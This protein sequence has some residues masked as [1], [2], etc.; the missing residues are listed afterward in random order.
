M[1]RQ[2]S[3]RASRG[4]WLGLLA[5][6][7]AVWLVAR[8]APQAFGGLGRLI[9]SPASSI[10]QEN[11]LPGTSAWTIPNLQAASGI[12]GYADVVSAQ[13]SDRVR[14]F[15]STRAAAFHVEAYRIGYYGG[16]GARL[17]WRSR[18]VRG[19]VQAGPSIDPATHMVEARWHPSLAFV[20]EPDWTPGD[21]LLKLV[22]RGGR[23]R[24]SKAG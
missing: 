16:H 6:L 5:L 3:A 1:K 22:G 7:S 8:V 23:Q 13:A 12:E 21:Y 17:V 10:E 20:V 19:E 9:R 4:R 24:V 18:S 15:V 14:L 2:R 11:R